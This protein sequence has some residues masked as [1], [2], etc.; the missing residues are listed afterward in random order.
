MTNEILFFLYIILVTTLTIFFSRQGK[1]H[2]FGWMALQ[3]ILANL[4]VI[5]QID[6]F[7]L[8]VTASDIYAVGAF[9]TLNIIQERF[10]KEEA[11]KAIF[12]ALSL[13]VAFVILSLAHLSYIPSSVDDTDNSFKT[14]LS[15]SLSIVFASILS[16][17]LSQ[18]LD[19]WLFQFIK[20]RLNY[21]FAVRSMMSMLVS[22]LF[23][24]CFFAVIALSGR[25]ESL[26]DIII[27]SY[28]IKALLV[29]TL[30]PS[31]AFAKRLYA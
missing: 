13:Q 25:V 19:V 8:T 2:L 18:K 31:F 17:L 24:T 9:L 5:K 29:V 26:T 23:D 28:A 10:G 20:E 22:Q 16:F 27:F 1:L 6:L 12:Y 14:I 4:F 7:A 11:N 15:P 21:P 30:N 3:I